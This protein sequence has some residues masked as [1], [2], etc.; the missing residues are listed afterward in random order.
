MFDFVETVSRA[1][2]FVK[3]RTYTL[4]ED[5]FQKD[6][7]IFHADLLTYARLFHNVFRYL[8]EENEECS[9]IIN[10]GSI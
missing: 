4:T 8:A 2:R 6:F 1:A 5:T 7:A 3:S 10:K 9:H